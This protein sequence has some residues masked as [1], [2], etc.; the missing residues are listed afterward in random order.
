MSEQTAQTASTE[1]PVVFVPTSENL[2]ALKQTAITAW[3]EVLKFADPFS[4]EAKDAK[5]AFLKIEGEIKAEEAGLNKAEADRKAQEAK[6]ERIKLFDDAMAAYKVLL[7]AP[8]AT[9][10]DK[11]AELQ[12]AFD[13]AR[14]EV[15]NQL[16]AKFGGSKP[17]A[18]AK[19]GEPKADNANKQAILDL[20][21]AG[22]KHAEIEA[23]LGVPRST[24]WHTIN[25]YKKANAS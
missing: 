19:D 23:E 1:T 21:H 24:V 6:N 16:L 8:K 4:K 3:G 9:T 15:V 18:A 13:T 2:T 17:A 12:N 7:Q 20:F 14:E 11:M 10:A 22:K 25:N 5:L